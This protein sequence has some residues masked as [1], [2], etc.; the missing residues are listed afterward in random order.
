MNLRKEL[1]MRIIK[2]FGF[3]SILWTFIGNSELHA[4]LDANRLDILQSQNDPAFEE[5]AKAFVE[6]VEFST[7]QSPRRSK[8]PGNLRFFMEVGGGAFDVNDKI[9]VN[10]TD[11]ESDPYVPDSFENLFFK[12]GTGLPFGFA[13]DAGFT[14]VLSE[15]KLNS[16][17]GNIA[18][19]ALDFA[20]LVYTDMVPSLAVSSGFNLILSG[21]SQFS[22]NTQAILGAY[23]RLW[24][25][26]VS[27]I[28]SFSWVNLTAIRPSYRHWFLRHGLSSHWPLFE[29]LYLT[30]DMHYK[31][32]EASI[33]LGYQF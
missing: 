31:P 22:I 27:Y 21:P 7:R 12:I 14:Q 9:L 16:I 30:A 4:A 3:F 11:A 20:N 15:H 10:F 17:H 24:M 6:A 19:Q 33:S 5:S 18:F 23:H 32:I 29:G 26:Q 2:Y 25:A 8:L 28:L 1:N 13:V